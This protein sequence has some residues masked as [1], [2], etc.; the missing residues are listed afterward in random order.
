MNGHAFEYHCPDN[1]VFN[2]NN[3]QCDFNVGPT[4]DPNVQTT[5]PHTAPSGTRQRHNTTP[6][7]PTSDP[8]VH[9][10]VPVGPTSDPNVHTTV[11]V[12]PTSDPN[13][14]TTDLHTAPSVTRQRH[15]ATP[16]SL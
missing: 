5:D 12:R 7:G 2:E 6:V 4:H 16:A 13:V 14:Q 15:T 11:P 10:T 3:N 8:N 1:L 9:T